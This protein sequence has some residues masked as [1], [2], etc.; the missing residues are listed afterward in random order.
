MFFYVFAISSLAK[1]LFS[2][3]LILNG[4]LSYYLAVRFLFIVDASPYISVLQILYFIN[5]ISKGSSF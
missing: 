3:L 1:F 5:C 2:Y 4:I